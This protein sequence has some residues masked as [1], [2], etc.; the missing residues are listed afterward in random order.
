MK[1]RTACLLTSLIFCITAAVSALD[2]R[3][4]SPNLESKGANL[5]VNFPCFC[6]QM[7]YMGGCY[8]KVHDTNCSESTFELRPNPCPPGTPQSCDSG[9]PSP[10]DCTISGLTKRANKPPM[11]KPL[12]MEQAQLKNLVG[13]EQAYTELYV[14]YLNLIDDGIKVK[15]HQ[16]LA[17]PPNGPSA[18]HWVGVEI[19]T[20]PAGTQAVNIHRVHGA[21]ALGKN[22]YKATPRLGQIRARLKM[23][24]QPKIL[25]LC[26]KGVSSDAP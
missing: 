11:A 7:N 23:A 3:G 14:V 18:V 25:V 22:E 26:S 21:K 13:G 17:Q 16:I 19:S 24:P 2:K 9:G 15:A 20:F 12:S 1:V 4:E 10:C 8:G 5:G 6:P